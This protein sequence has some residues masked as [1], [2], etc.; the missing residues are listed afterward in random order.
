MV[1]VDWAY[2]GVH[3]SEN[4]DRII[5]VTV[6]TVNWLRLHNVACIPHEC[7]V[8]SR[9]IV[10]FSRLLKTIPVTMWIFLER[11]CLYDA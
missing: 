11:E 2:A 5:H 1:L 3:V 8:L 7:R 10:T 9:S 4:S 6:F